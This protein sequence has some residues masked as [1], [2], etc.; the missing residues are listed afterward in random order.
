[1]RV[2]CQEIKKGVQPIKF[3]EKNNEILKCYARKMKPF[4]QISS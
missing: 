2:R 3:L 4:S 1:M